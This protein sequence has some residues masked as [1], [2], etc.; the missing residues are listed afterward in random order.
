MADLKYYG[1]NVLNHGLE[2]R[3]GN[4]SGSTI[5][6]GSFG[7]VNIVEMSVP[8]VSAVSSSVASRAATLEGTGTIQGV[9]QG[10]AVTFT[11]V[12]TGQGANEL[13]DMDQ[14]VKK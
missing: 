14:N 2:V 10:N 12:D 5:S 3:R 1:N 11:T 9:G 4:V 13:Y 8:S 7:N 6:T